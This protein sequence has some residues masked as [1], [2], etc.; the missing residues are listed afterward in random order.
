M[1]SKKRPVLY[2]LGVLAVC[3][4]ITEVALAIWLPLRECEQIEVEPDNPDE[5]STFQ[6]GP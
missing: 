3:V 4:L 2:A 1:S 6:E 5:K